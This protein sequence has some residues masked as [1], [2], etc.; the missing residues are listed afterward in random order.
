MYCKNCGKEIDNKAEICV[1][2]G[3]PVDNPG[4]ESIGTTKIVGSKTVGIVCIIWG[5]L[6][7]VIGSN[8]FGDIGVSFI[9]QGIFSFIIGVYLLRLKI[10]R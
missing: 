1:H 5:L 3:V 8:A 2:C 7:L 6:M 4:T 10:K 9:T